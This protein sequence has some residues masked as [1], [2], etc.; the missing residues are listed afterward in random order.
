MRAGL[1]MR[2]ARGSSRGWRG[3]A[4]MGLMLAA[5]SALAQGLST[6]RR[7]V[8]SMGAWRGVGGAGKDVA[9][10]RR[11]GWRG[12]AQERLRTGRD[13]VEVG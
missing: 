8:R 9:A 2:V 10:A 13:G 12:G 5:E 6:D 7:T 4:M 3:G 11:W 1:S